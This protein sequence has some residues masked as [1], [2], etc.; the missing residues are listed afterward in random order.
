MQKYKT[1]HPVYKYK[2]VWYIEEL[3]P[4]NVMYINTSGFASTLLYN[5]FCVGQYFFKIG[6]CLTPEELNEFFRS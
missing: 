6:E 3:Q 4:Q 1:T 2:H 5:I